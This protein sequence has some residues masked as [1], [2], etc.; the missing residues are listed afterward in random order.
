M[1]L[2]PKI[3]VIMA[4][5]I[6]MAIILRR[7]L[8]IHF[9]IGIISFAG[10]PIILAGLIYGPASGGIVGAVS[11]IL[12][13]PLYPV[14][15]YSPLFTLTSALTGIIPSFIAISIKKKDPVPLWLMVIVIFIGQFITKVLL[16]PFFLQL[17]FGVPF[18]WKS[19]TNLIVEL[20]HAPMY[21]LL[22]Q[23]VLMIYGGLYPEEAVISVVGPHWSRDY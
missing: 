5:L 8:T 20:I 12:G 3:I 2:K 9:P 17:H 15:P 16:V 22:A 1:K 21:A 14:G 10:F 7:I 4:L 11:D 18:I 23:P 19:L 13:Y 6:A